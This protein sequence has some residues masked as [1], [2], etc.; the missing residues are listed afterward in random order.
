[1]SASIRLHRGLLARNTALN[2]IGQALPL[3]VALATVP[4]VI[5]GLGTERFGLLAL[6]WMVLSYF[7]ELGFG[8]AAT[9]FVAEALGAGEEVRS[10]RLAWF[11]AVIQGGC[12]LVCAA[13]LALATPL[14][15]ER[16]LR[17]PPDLVGEARIVFYVVAAAVPV[18]LVHNSFRGVLEAMQRFDLVNAVRT[19]ASACNFILPAAGVLFG[20]SLPAIVALLMA[21]RLGALI[22]YY[23]AAWH[24]LPTMRGWPQLGGREL[25]KIAGFGGWSTVSGIVSPAL[26]YLDRFL[27]GSLVAVSAVAYYAAPY[28]LVTRLLII[29]GSLTAA[30]FPAFSAL[31]G[32]RQWDQVGR[33]LARTVKYTLLLIGPF[34]VLVVAAATDVLGLW[35][36]VSYA[37]EGALALQILALGVLVN[38]LAQVPFSLVQGIGRPDIGAK[39][40]LLE[41]PIHLFVA[42]GLIYLLGIPGAAL[43]WTLRVTLDA[44]LLFAAARRLAPI[45][46]GGLLAERVPQTAMLLLGFGL[47]A[48]TATTWASSVWLRLAVLTAIVGTM[49]A[50]VWRYSLSDGDRANLL[51][52]AHAGVVR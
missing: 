37:Q 29:P 28:E 33:L 16:I 51:R 22:A 18:M 36:D 10:G 35:L 25:R 23:G 20:W 12:G 30:V 26:V 19:P 8:R 50:T 31:Q 9:K 14:L 15:V 45:P 41:L 5:R 2:L 11:A 7:S 38:S 52:W 32:Q 49:A 3:L 27:L 47:V 24:V 48:T 43:A 13:L 1:M 46:T 4:Y 21:A 34:V 6:A 39:L 40:H 17:M 44:A 42:T